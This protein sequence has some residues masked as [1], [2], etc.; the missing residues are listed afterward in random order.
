MSFEIF[1]GLTLRPGSCSAF[2][3]GENDMRALVGGYIILFI[4]TGASLV[5]QIVKNPPAVQETWA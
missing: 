3:N 2:T 1:L 4:P 5:A